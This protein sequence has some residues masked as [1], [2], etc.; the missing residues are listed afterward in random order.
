MKEIGGRRTKGRCVAAVA[1]AAF[2]AAAS[3]PVRSSAAAPDHNLEWFAM[4]LGG[5]ATF[6][7]AGDERPYAVRVQGRATVQADLLFFN[8]QRPGWYW[9]VIELHPVFSLVGMLGGG[10]RA[11]VRIPLSAGYRDEL[12]IGCF[13]G[14]ELATFHINAVHPTLSMRPHLQYVHNTGSGSI[15]VGADALIN[16]HFRD[17]MTGGDGYIF[18]V[19]PVA[20]GVTIYLRW[21]YGR[22]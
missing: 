9:S 19:P 10:T 5:G 20:S 12:R 6:F 8:L 18:D 4:N 2:V 3:V 13:A 17:E 22:R 16:L 11:G 14:M 21:S 7:N 15:G 1:V